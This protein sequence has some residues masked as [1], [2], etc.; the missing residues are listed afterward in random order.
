MKDIETGQVLE[1]VV[2]RPLK[3][4][5]RCRL[6]DTGEP[7]T[8]RLN[9]LE[10]PGEIITVRAAR[11]WKN[12][13][14]RYLSGE[15]L[16]RRIDISVL[17]LTP[18]KVVYGGEMEEDEFLLD[19]EHPLEIREL[20]RRVFR[21]SSRQMYEMEQVIPGSSSYDMDDDAILLAVDYKNRGE[22]GMAFD[23]LYDLLEQDLRCLDAYAHLGNLHL[24]EEGSKNSFSAERALNFY[25]VGVTMGD[26]FLGEDFQG[27]LPWYCVDNRPY[28]RCLKGYGLALDRLGRREEATAAFV[29]LLRFDPHDALGARFLLTGSRI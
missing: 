23:A 15:K 25:T 29:R 9:R 7:V 8:Y 19:D 21:D 13:R 17:G 12:G 2:T 11:C 18:L 10:V 3:V 20:Y 5:L 27:H 24:P 1:L 28:L 4:A 16:G 26:H 6:L 22:Y 14:T